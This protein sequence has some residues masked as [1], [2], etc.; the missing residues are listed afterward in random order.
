MVVVAVG[1]VVV[2]GAETSGFRSTQAPRERRHPLALE[3]ASVKFSR[4]TGDAN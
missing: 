3:D 2:V 4:E 1:V